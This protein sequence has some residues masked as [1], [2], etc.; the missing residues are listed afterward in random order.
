M[1]KRYAVSNGSLKYK[2][3]KEVYS[4]KQEGSSINEYYTTMKGMWEELDSLDQLPA[5]TSEA[6]DVLKLLEVLKTQ[7]EE[8]RLFQFLNGL[9]EIYGVQRSHLLMITPL[10]SVEFTC[11]TLQ[12][13]ESQR[14][15][16]DP[17]ESLAMY[18]R[19]RN[20]TPVCGACG[21]KG[22][23]REKC[24][25]LVG[26]PKWHPKFKSNFKGRDFTENP[27]GQNRGTSNYLNKAKGARMVANAQG[28]SHQSA[29]SD[30]TVQQLEQ[31]LRSLPSSRGKAVSSDDEMEQNFAGFAGMGILSNTSIDARWIIDSGASD[32]MTCDDACVENA[33]IA[34]EGMKINL[35]NGEC[36]KITK[37]GTVRLKNGLTLYNVLVVPEFK[38]NLLS[39][40]KLTNSGKCKVNFYA[41]YCMIVD[42]DSSK[43]RGIGECRNGLYYLMNDDMKVIVDTL[44]N[45]S[46]H[47]GF[48]AEN[49]ADYITYGWINSQEHGDMMLW[50]L[51]L[52]HT[53]FSKLSSMGLNIKPNP[54]P[55]TQ[56][57]CVT[58]PMAKLTKLPFLHS[59]SYTTYPF[60]LI[61]IDTWG[62]YKVQTRGKHRYFLAVVDDYTRTTWVTLLQH[63][64]EAFEAL[65][66]FVKTAATQFNHK[67]NVVR[68]DN[69]LEFKDDQCKHLYE[70]NDIFH[71]TSCVHT[72]Q[73]NGKVERKHMNIL[74]MARCLRFQ[75][76]L[77]K[78]YWGDCVLTAAYLTNRI[79]P[80]SSKIKHLIKCYITIPLHMPHS[81]CLAFLLWP[82]TSPLM[83]TNLTLGVCHV[84]S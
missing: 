71:Q 75:V 68:S 66:K 72:A 5:V 63:K 35:P 40:N 21:V 53:P 32:H 42:Q 73:Q 82:T 10:P 1:E 28:S 12:Q 45:P 56:P 20:D 44:A 52:G 59:Q 34:K 23:L 81:R 43:L 6:D 46:Y 22:H 51:R 37:Y 38:H 64:S 3:N 36:S 27:N 67:V 83:Q 8:R 41:G 17:V 61:H 79:P 60:E 26:Y 29:T 16:L 69:A 74:E 48:S 65:L 19:G 24:W 50:H 84:C 55:H 30:F 62:P 47:T 25:T 2:L 49:A 77:P 4:L 58:C 15:I 13:E 18:S 31:L 76:G 11:N 57:T 70:S 9:N 7:R 14:S 78:T 54:K 80:P 39:V 33:R